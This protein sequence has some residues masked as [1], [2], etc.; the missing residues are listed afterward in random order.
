MDNWQ[1]GEAFWGG[2]SCDLNWL[3]LAK[4]YVIEKCCNGYRS[5][6]CKHSSMRSNNVDCDAALIVT[7]CGD[8]QSNNSITITTTLKSV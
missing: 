4:M 5:R 2:G 8:E 1:G 6:S 3:K 7:S